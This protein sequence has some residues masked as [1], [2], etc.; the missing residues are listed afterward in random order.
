MIN[1]FFTHISFFPN[2]FLHYFNY[3]YTI[4]TENAYWQQRLTSWD[5][6]MTP[7]TVILGLFFL[8]IIFLPVGVTML[9]S[10]NNLYNMSIQYGGEG[11]QVANQC[12]GGACLL[13]FVIDQAVDG[14]LYLYYELDN[15]YQ[16]N[17]KYSSSVNWD[18][19]MGKTNI[20]M[21]DLEAKCD[22][23]VTNSTLTLNPC[24]LIAKSYFTDSYGLSLTTSSVGG[25]APT[26]LKM[27]F[28]DITGSIDKS[29][30]AQPEGHDSKPLPVGS[31]C[32]NRAIMIDSVCTTAG[33]PTGCKCY[34]NPA[35]AAEYYYFYYPNDATNLYLY[36]MYPQSTTGGI[37]PLV[38]VTDP[39]FMNWMN[40]AALPNFR[41]LYGVIE[42]K[43]S[44]G[45]ILSF[46]VTSLVDVGSFKGKKS[47]VL[48]SQGS[49]GVSNP[50]L[51]ITYIVTGGACL[52][53]SIIFFLKQ[54]ISPRPLPTPASLHWTK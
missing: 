23:A 13:N 54:E 40:I 39:H 4:Y 14:K 34:Q 8:G 45:D 51:G 19:M 41:K 26:A 21:S 37:S 9:Y 52:L 43:F 5:P 29:L 47:L 7:F 33:L 35:N 11:T 6:V 28:S 16:N 46:A 50:G 42:G 31:T 3:K 36:E 27:S 12:A 30:F 10:A 38:G 1:L 48:S 32:V 20:P 17:I 15:Y 18:Q 22:P 25:T 24:G 49:L 44:S 2:I 53:F